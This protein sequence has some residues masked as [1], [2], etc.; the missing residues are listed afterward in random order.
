MT[1]HGF[2]HILPHCNGGYVL[3]FDEPCACG[4]IGAEAELSNKERAMAEDDKVMQGVVISVDRT[5]AAENSFLEPSAI[6]VKANNLVFKSNK[7]IVKA[8][9]AQSPGQFI[10]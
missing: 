2:A 1:S 5:P 10:E 4:A 6:Q 3:S 9:D 8:H 7:V